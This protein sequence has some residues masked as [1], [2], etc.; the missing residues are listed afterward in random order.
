MVYKD[1]VALRIKFIGL[2]RT[3]TLI[4]GFYKDSSKCPDQ[5]GNC[6]S[7]KKLLVHGVTR[8]Y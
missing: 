1:D 2:L 3:R 7:F 5:P 8:K 4:F 6:R